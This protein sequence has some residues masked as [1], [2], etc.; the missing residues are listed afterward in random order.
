MSLAVDEIPGVK[1]LRGFLYSFGMRRCG[2]RFQ[3]SSDC[4]LWGLECL[5]VG[6]DVYLAP[7]VMLFCADEVSLGDG[8]L[9]APHVVVSSGNHLEFTHCRVCRSPS[10]GKDFQRLTAF[11]GTSRL[12]TGPPQPGQVLPKTPR[13][14][15]LG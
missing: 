2:R 15:Q 4:R 13:I 6:D 5:S 9:I 14:P 8:V 1:A 3:V 11:E 10:L 12:K 7:G